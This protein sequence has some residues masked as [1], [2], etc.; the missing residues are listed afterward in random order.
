MED[1]Y[2]RKDYHDATMREIKALMEAN[3]AKQEAMNAE[4]KG[5]IKNINTRI[6]GV[7]DTFSVAIN[8][9]KE[10]ID[11]I[12]TSQ[13][14]GFA[15]WGIAVALFIGIVQVTVALLLK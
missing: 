5:D 2:V 15:R 10:R 6:D 11:D 1:E 12:K 14:N 13:S 4:I 9:L 8:D 7:V 3:L